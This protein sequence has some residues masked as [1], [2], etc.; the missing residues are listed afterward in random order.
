MNQEY[1]P[2]KIEKTVQKFWEDNNCYRAI[3]NDQ[4]KF[5]CL[6]MFPYPSGKLH[7][8][9]VRNY[10]IGDVISRYKRMRGFNVLQPMGWDAFGLPA[11]NAAIQNKVDP[12]T[13]TEKNIANMKLQLKQLGFSYD[14]TKE[15]KT[16]DP[17]YYRWEQEM[18]TLLQD[19]GLVYKKK[20]LVNWD[21]LI[22]RF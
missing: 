2:Q 19:N 22:K 16:C 6:S 3:K 9:H 4:K 7:M 8:G 11:E 21:Q 15:L 13:W 5:Y 14:W 10:T 12:Q 1:N 17:N 18:F 20:S